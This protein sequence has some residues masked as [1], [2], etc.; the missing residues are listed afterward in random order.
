VAHE[1]FRCHDEQEEEP[2]HQKGKSGLAQ[3]NYT[4]DEPEISVVSPSTGPSS[5]DGT[6]DVKAASVTYGEMTWADIP[7]PT[8]ADMAMLARDYHFHQLDLE[9]CLSPRQLTKVEDHGD[10]IF[11][12]LLFPDEVGKK[13]VASGHVSMFMGKDYLVTMHASGL[14]T[15]SA[16]FQSCREDE[17]ERGEFMK[18]PAYLAYRI[19]DRLVDGIFSILEDVQVSLDSIEAVVFDEKKSSAGPINLARRQIATLRR[20]VY[21]LSLYL[22]DLTRAQKFSKEDL[23]IYFSD[24]RHKIL[25]VSG[26]IEEMK[27]I[28]EIYNDT[29]FDTSSNRTNTVLSILTIFFTLTLPAAVLAAVYGMNVPLPGAITPGPLEF[30]GTYTSLIFILA[31]MIIPTAIMASYFRRRGWF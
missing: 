4:D 23:S 12:S 28:V 29:D 6:G 25:K 1:R 5:N 8:T 2:R 30:F 24:I 31:A 3:A 14:E 7:D 18:S 15:L 21:P 27:E 11:I 19:I 10:H 9:D 17:K 26:I 16:L 13:V 20:I 22:P